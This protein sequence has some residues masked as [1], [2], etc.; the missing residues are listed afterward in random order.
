[1]ENI[2]NKNMLETAVFA[3][4][5][6]WGVEYMMK[7]LHG[8]KSITCGF[9]GGTVDKP[10]Y[11]R[12]CQGDTGH[13]ECVKIEFDPKEV[14]YEELAKHFFE[15]HDTSTEN[16]QGPD[17]GIQYRSEIFYTNDNQK[18]VA[19]KLIDILKTKGYKVV[20]KVTPFIAFYKAED[21]HQDYYGR[22][23]THPYC[24]IYEKKFD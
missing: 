17:V 2:I 13:A 21:Y 8:V 22:Q 15:I 24:H 4:G 1:M 14:S 19:E 16:Q 11:H 5:C 23:G 9:S 6:F 3:G 18:T 20:T 7:K 12:V 10:S